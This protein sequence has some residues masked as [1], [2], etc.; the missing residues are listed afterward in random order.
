MR[1]IE[2][3]GL[4]TMHTLFLLEHNRIARELQLQPAMQK[5]LQKLTIEEQNEV[6]YQET[7][8]LLAATHQ[9]ITY[10]EFLPLVLGPEN[11]QKY[12]LE[13]KEG[14]DSKYNPSLDP[15]IMNEFA[16]VSFRFGHTLVPSKFSRVSNTGK[17]TIHEQFHL[18]NTFFNITF[19]TTSNKRAWWL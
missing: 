14:T 4:L 11:M 3:P 18:S 9:A 12:E 10:K 16:T 17:R 5:Y 6:V 2:A 13:L 1:C 7:R 15:T 8:R 19:A